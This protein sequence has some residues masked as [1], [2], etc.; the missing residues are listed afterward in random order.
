MDA[1]KA[2]VTTAVILARGLGTRMRAASDSAVLS[3]GQSNMADRG[4]KG[5]IDVGGPFLD[6]VIT[7]AADAGIS[8]VILVVGPEHDEIRRYYRTLPTE[9]LTIEFAE[10]AEPRGTGDAVAS[11][12]AL[13]GTDD[14]LVLNSDN[15]YP[16]STLLRLQ[17]ATGCALV[18]FE[19]AV[20]VDAGNI[21]AERVRS[22]ALVEASENGR[23]ASIIEKPDEQTVERLGSDALVS[24]NCYRFTSAIFPHLR[25][26]R[27]SS[28]GEYELT[29][30]VR[31]AV[32]A[33]VPFEIVTTPDA[34]LDLSTRGDVAGVQAALA[35]RSVTL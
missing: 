10:Q 35:G 15:Y 6:H 9:R 16:G 4:V 5:M 31:N 13:V 30:A 32:A 34:V 28:R 27:P 25:A 26:L 20:L 22:F 21:P 1:V 8:R 33:G 2:P 11:A 7:A 3:G 14:F 18:G 12:E 17:D 19:A 24:M 23:L 29:E